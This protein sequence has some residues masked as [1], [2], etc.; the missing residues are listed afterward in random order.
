VHGRL[1]L[2]EELRAG[3]VITALALSLTHWGAVLT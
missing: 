2:E 3:V 1:A